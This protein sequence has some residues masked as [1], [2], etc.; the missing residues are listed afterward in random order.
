MLNVVS[1]LKKTGEFVTFLL[2]STA[3]PSWWILGMKVGN[4]ATIGI[5]E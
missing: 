5:F 4:T 2:H 1:E 3:A